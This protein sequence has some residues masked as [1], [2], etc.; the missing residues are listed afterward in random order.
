MC[1]L[2]HMRE[3][4][5]QERIGIGS[6]LKGQTRAHFR[7]CSHWIIRYRC[8]WPLLTR[9][10]LLRQK[11]Y[12]VRYTDGDSEEL[13]TKELVKWMNKQDVERYNKEWARYKGTGDCR[14]SRT[15]CGPY[16]PKL[17]TPHSAMCPSTLGHVKV[18]VLNTKLVPS[19]LHILPC[20]LNHVNF[21]VLNTKPSNLCEQQRQE[22]SGSGKGVRGFRR[23]R[24]SFRK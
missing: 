11:F 22:E 24:S 19:T 4:L 9:D 20:A 23:K 14:F 2:I 7:R 15:H 6:A 18:V 8:R 1:V 16:R 21:L 12:L 13:W 5:D 17:H 3:W 10:L